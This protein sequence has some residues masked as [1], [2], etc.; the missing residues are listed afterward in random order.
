MEA[1]CEAMFNGFREVPE[2]EKKKVQKYH[3]GI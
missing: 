1:F 3:F 2:A